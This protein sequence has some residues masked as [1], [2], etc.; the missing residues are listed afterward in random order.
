[1]VAPQA[2]AQQFLQ[3][4]LFDRIAKDRNLRSLIV[5]QDAQLLAQL[6]AEKLKGLTAQ[7]CAELQQFA[8]LQVALG[9]AEAAEGLKNLSMRLA[10]ADLAKSGALNR[11]AMRAFIGDPQALELLVKARASF[12][13]GDEQF[14]GALRAFQREL[15]VASQG[16]QLAELNGNVKFRAAMQQDAEAM[17][18]LAGSR[19]FMEGLQNQAFLRALNNQAFLRALGSSESAELFANLRLLEALNDASVMALA[20]KANILMAL[21]SSEALREALTVRG[22]HEALQTQSALQSRLAA[23]DQEGLNKQ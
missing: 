5:S 21:Q 2:A 18:K 16:G 22:F 7:D 15:A 6:N 19:A 10:T 23:L 3:S 17:L 12:Q 13:G 1:V 9:G 14:V 11:G 20:S 8:N 4:D